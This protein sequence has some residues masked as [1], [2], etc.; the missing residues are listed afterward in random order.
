LAALP[1][2]EHDDGKFPG[3]R[4]PGPT[5]P[6]PLFDPRSPGVQLDVRPTSPHEVDARLH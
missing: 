6:S 1:D 3:K 4:N 5:S 2:R